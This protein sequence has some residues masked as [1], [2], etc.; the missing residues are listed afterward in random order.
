M[1]P[2]YGLRKIQVE[3]GLSQQSTAVTDVTG[4]G[5]QLGRH[6]IGLLLAGAVQLPLAAL[7]AVRHLQI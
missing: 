4:Q 6:W 3:H 1:A 5:S 2:M 7:S